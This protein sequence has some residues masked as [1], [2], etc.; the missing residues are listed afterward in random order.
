MCLFDRQSRD[1][2]VCYIFIKI[3]KDSAEVCGKINV[4]SCTVK[5]YHHEMIV[6]VMFS[7]KNN[8]ALRSP[9]PRI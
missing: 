9:R 4:F 6:V 3:S 1:A 5:H 2:T 8:P 7:T